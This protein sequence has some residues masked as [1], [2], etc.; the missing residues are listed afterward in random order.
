MSPYRIPMATAS[1]DGLGHDQRVSDVWDSPLSLAVGA[2]QI[3][4]GVTPP[5]VLGIYREHAELAED[6]PI[7]DDRADD[8]YF[9]VAV[10]D[11][12][13]WPSLVVTQ[14][15]APSGPGFD[16]AVLYVPEQRQLF[17]GAGIRLMAYEARLDRW[18]R[19]W[20]DE[21]E[22]GFWSWRQH[23]DV[24]IMSAEL[25]LAAWRTDGTKLWTTSVEPP[26]SYQVISDQVMLDVMGAVRTFDLRRGP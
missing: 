15:Y 8:G 25:E 20:A 19:C 13:E 14:R 5:D 21:A 24:V 9:F 17:I 22:F 16:P 7:A 10:N 4:V 3:L 6:F 11:D 2:T 26:W 12:G 23:D 1:G 18:R